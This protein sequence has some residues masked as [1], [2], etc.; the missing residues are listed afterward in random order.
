MVV[1]TKMSMSLARGNCRKA[2][3]I[4]SFFSRT[5]N[6]TRLACCLSDSFAGT[7]TGMRLASPTA[8]RLFSSS[9][10][11]PS[12]ALVDTTLASPSQQC[13]SFTSTSFKKSSSSQRAM[14]DLLK[15]KKVFECRMYE[16]SSAGKLFHILQ[17]VS[18]S[19]EAAIGK[20]LQ[21]SIFQELT[22]ANMLELDDSYY[23]I[24]GCTS[25]DVAD[26]V[27]AESSYDKVDVF[28]DVPSTL[29][30][31]TTDYFQLV[32]LPG[33]NVFSS[34][35]V[36]ADTVVDEVTRIVQPGGF[37][38]VHYDGTEGGKT[39]TE[40]AADLDGYSSLK[41]VEERPSDSV[42]LYKVV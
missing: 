33:T 21:K 9:S 20:V 29:S 42:F 31:F 28:S 5:S 12:F 35:S 25:P 8:P 6:H 36:T 22:D 2:T 26:A 38:V 23:L 17:L 7:G 1:S 3:M 10:P 40:F 14:A 13:R 11:S 18:Q 34:S 27:K 32:V 15:D 30:S 16:P 37:V 24:A 19:P 4:S 41:L 39:P